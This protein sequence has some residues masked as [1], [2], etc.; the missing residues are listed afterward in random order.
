MTGRAA[1]QLL[2]PI[3]LDQLLAQRDLIHR[4][5]VIHTEHILA[6][7]HIAFR[8]AVALEAPVHIERVF[9]PRERHRV[10]SAVT[11]GAANA[12]VNVNAMIEIN[13][14]GKVVDSGPLNRL[15]GAKTL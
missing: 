2:N 12:L 5:L 8:S 6:R 4:R 10:D 11:G 1:R 9:T 7:S 13:K 3:F 15:A 14:T